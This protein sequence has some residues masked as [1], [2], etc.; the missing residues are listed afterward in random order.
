MSIFSKKANQSKN[1]IQLADQKAQESLKNEM[2]GGN[3]KQDPDSPFPVL[4]TKNGLTWLNDNKQSVFDDVKVELTLSGKNKEVEV[5]T[6]IEAIKVVII[7]PRVGL[8]QYDNLEE[9][10]KRMKCK[11]IAAFSEE[12]E[13]YYRF[14]D[15]PGEI[16]IYGPA[17]YDDDHKAN[18]VVTK[19]GFYGSKGMF[20]SDCVASGGHTYTYKDENDKDVT[21]NCSG[22][23]EVLVA[24]TAFGIRDKIR[25]QDDSGKVINKPVVEWK[26]VDELFYD[27]EVKT[28]VF[29]NSPI[30]RLKMTNKTA[31]YRKPFDVITMANKDSSDPSSK[32]VPED[33]TNFA[34][35]LQNLRREELDDKMPYII[36][37][38]N[39]NDGS[40]FNCYRGLHE[41]WF[42]R[43]G[44]DASVSAGIKTLPMFRLSK[45]NEEVI[46]ESGVEQLTSA[47]W[48]FIKE[49]WEEQYNYFDENNLKPYTPFTPPELEKANQQKSLTGNSGNE[50]NSSTDSVETNSFNVE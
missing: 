45:E 7:R 11:T 4:E 25:T 8:M 17:S 48:D 41:V 42:T 16:P 35:H 47:T 19:S 1:D 39:P 26:D 43:P 38:V 23:T 34:L 33:V 18:S 6:R 3:Y 27:D 46:N 10:G 31:Y 12:G 14:S 2:G 24:I 50:N 36:R 13:E 9:A 49:Y 5:A 15:T 20:C 21:V 37:A 30:V 40:V 28:R 22:R 44:P 32:F 29:T